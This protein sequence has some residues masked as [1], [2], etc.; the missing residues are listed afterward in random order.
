MVKYLQLRLNI[1]GSIQM[2][3][4]IALLQDYFKVYQKEICYAYRLSL[5]ENTVPL[6]SG[7]SLHEFPESLAEI[8]QNLNQSLQNLKSKGIALKWPL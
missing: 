4:A 2:Q 8:I 6:P 7:Q 5:P 1:Y 3:E